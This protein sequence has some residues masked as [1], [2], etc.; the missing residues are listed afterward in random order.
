M[1][2][3]EDHQEFMVKSLRKAASYFHV[4]LQGDPVFGWRDRFIVMRKNF[5]LDV[6]LN[7]SSNISC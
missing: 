2:Q 1:D 6:V 4:T 5:F 7:K 3:W